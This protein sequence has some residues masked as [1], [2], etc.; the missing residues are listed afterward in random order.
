LHGRDILL[1]GVIKRIGSGTTTYVWEDNWLPANISLK[2]IVR[3]E[4][5]KATTVADLIIEGTHQWDVAKLK[6]NFIEMDIKAIQKINLGHY[7]MEDVHA[8]S[9]EKN[10]VY[11]VRS[12]YWLLKDIQMSNAEYKDSSTS[13]SGGPGAWWK[14]LWKMKIPPKVR[15]FWWQSIH[16]F[17]SAKSNLFYRHIAKDGACMN[18]GYCAET[19]YHTMFECSDAKRFWE[20][21]RDVTSKKPPLLHLATWAKDLLVGHLCKTDAAALFACCCS[22]L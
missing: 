15:I 17:L 9:Y 10:G 2:P 3:L 12:A 20:C 11:F 21:I 16:D 1:R 14:H 4:S 18:C 8:W 6:E 7:M 19:I 13:G 22:S 5:A